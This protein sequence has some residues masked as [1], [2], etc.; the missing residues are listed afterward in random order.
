M[1]AYKSGY[2]AKY[3]NNLIY[4]NGSTIEIIFQFENLVQI[5]D[6]QIAPCGTV[7]VVTS[8]KNNYD[9]FS[10][11]ILL[12]DHPASVPTVKVPTVKLVNSIFT[13]A[14][15]Y[16]NLTIVQ[17]PKAEPYHIFGSAIIFISPSMSRMFVYGFEKNLPKL[18][19]YIAITTTKTEDNQDLPVGTSVQSILLTNLEVNA[20]VCVAAN[21]F[22][23]QQGPCLFYFNHKFS[24]VNFFHGGKISKKTLINAIQMRDE[25]AFTLVD[26][27]DK[28]YISTPKN[29][30]IFPNE[31]YRRGFFT[32]RVFRCKRFEKE[33]SIYYEYFTQDEKYTFTTKT[34]LNKFDIYEV[35][36]GLIVVNEEFGSGAKMRDLQDNV[37]VVDF[38]Y[39]TKEAARY[40]DGIVLDANG[41]HFFIEIVKKIVTNPEGAEKSILDVKLHNL[42]LT[43][44][45]SICEIDLIAHNEQII[46]R[47]QE[48]DE[49]KETL[50]EFYN[51][52]VRTGALEPV[53]F[54]KKLIETSD[55]FYYFDGCK[56]VSFHEEINLALRSFPKEKL[57][58]INWE[59]L[60]ID[61]LSPDSVVHIDKIRFVDINKNISR[62]YNKK[63][64]EL[65]AATVYFDQNEKYLS[66]FV[67]ARRANNH[68]NILH[69]MIIGSS[70]TGPVKVAVNA[71]IDEFVETYFK[72]DG[73]FLIPT[74]A[75]SNAD[76]D[77]KIIL[78]WCLHNLVYL[79]EGPIGHHLPLAL[80]GAIVD[81]RHLNDSELD[82]YAKLS[83]PDLYTTLN[84][85]PKDQL[86][87]SGYET[88]AEWLSMMCRYSH[89]DIESYKLLAEG[90]KS[91]SEKNPLEGA[92]IVTADYFIS[93]SYKI[94]PAKLI[95]NFSIGTSAEVFV[96]SLSERLNAASQTQIRNFV[97]NI[98]GSYHLD[99]KNKIKIQIDEL[100][101]HAYKLI[102]CYKTLSI[103]KDVDASSYDALIDGLLKNQQAKIFG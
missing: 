90:F 85:M 5:Q 28:K 70:G 9:L 3:H 10:V 96:V 51:L 66:K 7:I 63:T 21:T 93:G 60:M 43:T 81:R 82:Y 22:V 8:N 75:F 31:H 13:V 72:I 36:N 87:E 32:Q 11:Y 40:D 19:K 37:L 99:K 2:L 46:V 71:I 65:G 59:M 24:S 1:W 74:Q 38:D 103:S 94:K 69:P 56:S 29:N 27:E 88:R 34:L 30:K 44:S 4:A 45:D 91:F 33:E 73:F 83:D 95:S 35:P 20:C 68:H 15:F 67:M 14:K 47:K 52:D 53:I 86:A 61:P 17:W 26:S 101:T 39:F 102:V 6:L 18:E 77:L 58:K 48:L 64:S 41:E 89:S 42:K 76:S 12:K 78:G 92:N 25:L 79:L 80:L 57:S 97:F 54:N 49:S 84:S 55:G 100:K 16:Q 23:F 50:P 98:T 62:T